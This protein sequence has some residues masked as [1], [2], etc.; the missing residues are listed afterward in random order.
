MAC[1]ICQ[2]RR[3]RRLCPGIGGEICPVCCGRERENTVD[4]PLECEYLQAARGREKMPDLDPESL[5]N[6]DIEV[7]EDFIREQGAL[8]Q[9][10]IRGLATA[11][12]GMPGAVDL[13]V[14]EALDSLAR[15]YRTRESGLYYESK[16]AN[17]VAARIFELMQ[18]G[19]EE[20]RKTA[21]ERLGIAPVRDAGILGVLVFLQRTGMQFD[22]GRRRRRA[23]MEFLRQHAGMGQEAGVQDS[24]SPLV[25]P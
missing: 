2:T 21:V 18:K 11:A 19:L 4:C 3:A 6:R 20:F 25:L 24:G 7:S 10:T 8:L 23:F 16:P 22:N 5:P 17:L 15:T 13:D 1:K 14:R 12:W 9:A